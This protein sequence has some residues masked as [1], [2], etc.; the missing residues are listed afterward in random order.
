MEGSIVVGVIVVVDE[1]L[2]QNWALASFAG[3]MSFTFLL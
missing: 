2:A 1:L 3:P